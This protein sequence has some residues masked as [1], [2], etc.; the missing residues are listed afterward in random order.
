[1]M[2]EQK[3]AQ[4]ENR[5][6]KLQNRNKESQGV[7]RKIQREMRHMEKVVPSQKLQA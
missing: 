7:C 6:K 4:L 1:M 3:Y 5:L 2:N